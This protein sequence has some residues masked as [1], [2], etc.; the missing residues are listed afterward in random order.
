MAAGAAG[1]GGELTAP[2]A[3]LELSNMRDAM[4]DR[5]ERSLAN[6]STLLERAETMPDAVT[7][8]SCAE[9]AERNKQTAIRAER[10]AEAL[11]W[12]LDHIPEFE[13]EEHH[14]STAS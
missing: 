4:R 7:R 1:E 10:R 13:M 14:V 3:R 2:E 12:A 9:F 6:W 11:D 8:M 5:A